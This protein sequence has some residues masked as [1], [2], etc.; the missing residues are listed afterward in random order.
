MLIEK[1]EAQSTPNV[2]EELAGSWKRSI[3]AITLMIFL[4][5]PIANH[6]SPGDGI[7]A[8]V[9]REA[10]YWAF[11]AIL[12]C[13]I[14]LVERRPLSSVGLCRP[15][16]KSLVYGIVGAVTMIAGMALI[17]L[18]VFPL[19]G[20]SQVESRMATVKALPIWFRLLLVV[21]AAVFEELY[22]RGFMIERL[23]EIFRVRWVAA[24]ISLTAFTF[25]HLGYWGWSHLI[26]A[27]FGGR[28]FD[29][30]LPAPARSL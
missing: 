22:F 2:N 29:W 10:V 12:V 18:V 20:V 5:L 14:R 19:L 6:L 8:Q 23:T 1:S 21:R 25:A 26:I 24:T 7:E 28:Y 11:T 9:G 27:G 4:L 16:R 13:Y 3:T 17:Y 30:V 15:T